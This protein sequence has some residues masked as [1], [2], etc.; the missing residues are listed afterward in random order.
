MYLYPYDS[1]QIPSDCKDVSMIGSNK[2]TYGN[3][4]HTGFLS[5]Q[6]KTT[7][8]LH[9][10]DP[11]YNI[12]GIGTGVLLAGDARSAVVVVIDYN[13]SD[14]SS[15]L[16]VLNRVNNSTVTQISF[17]ND[18]LAAA[19]KN[20]GLYIYNGGLGFFL[21]PV[22]GGPMSRI[23]TIDNY[24]D[25]SMVGGDALVQTTAIIAGLHGDGS[26][27]DEPSLNFSVIAYGCL[28]SS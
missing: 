21:N 5:A 9:F 24:R 18:F 7:K 23:F 8:L 6:S 28:L 26:F 19:F 25:V 2:T 17:S 27:F 12:P 14:F 10:I 1:I 15:T 13:N 20:N 11:D 16:Y 3:L 4:I 22:T